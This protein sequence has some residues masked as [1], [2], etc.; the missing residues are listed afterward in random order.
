MSSI[1]A[2]VAIVDAHGHRPDH[3]LE[4][5]QDLERRAWH[6]HTAP[7]T[8]QGSSGLASI[9]T[10]DLTG[11]NKRPAS[12]SRCRAFFVKCE[13]IRSQWPHIRAGRSKRLNSLSNGFQLT[14][15]IRR[16]AV[17]RDV[18]SFFFRMFA[19]GKSNRFV[20]DQSQHLVTTK[21]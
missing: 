8:P 19:D 6:G 21:P 3:R 17:F 16:F 15:A 14:Q 5:R 1:D 4:I 18:E 20:D 10:E 13:I 12:R 2:T 9:G 11:T 7:G